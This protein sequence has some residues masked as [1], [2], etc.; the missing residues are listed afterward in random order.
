LKTPLFQ[1]LYNSALQRQ[2]MEENR[3]GKK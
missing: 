2:G 3:T 1:I